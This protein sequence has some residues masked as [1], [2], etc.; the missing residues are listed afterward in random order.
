[1][2]LNFRL[3]EPKNI[4][5]VSKFLLP[6]KLN[7]RGYNAWL[8]KALEELRWGSK[9]AVLG[10]SEDVLV[11]A[12]LFQNCKHLKGFTEL[13]SGR[14]IEEYSNRL[15]LSFEIRQVEAISK[16]EGKLGI[17]CDSRSDRL[18]V[19]NLLRK[20]NYVEIARTDL[21]KEG[22]EDVVMMKSF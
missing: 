2:N 17:I 8:Q 18:D 10:F 1:M 19:L 20:N 21:Y 5:C 6:R 15:F 9:D 7:Y 3:F 12:L 4:D 16:Q 11:S 13:K 22:Y 14:T